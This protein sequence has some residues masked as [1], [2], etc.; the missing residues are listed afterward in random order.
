MRFCF[1]G[2]Y[3]VGAG[4]PVNRVLLAGLNRAGHTV[5]VCRAEVWGPFVHRALSTHNP[6]RLLLLGLRL[7]RGWGQLWWR[8]RRLE[9][10]PDWIVV[11][12]PGFFD[13]HLAHWLARGRPVALVSF[14]SLYD[15]IVA[16]R[17][18]LPSGSRVAGLLKQLDR[19]A[20][21]AADAVLVD[22]DEQARYY[23]D[24]F[25]LDPGRFLRSF[26]G[27]DDVEFSFVPPAPRGPD[28][29]RV[30]FFGTYV[31]L[32][33]IE[34]VID[35]AC[36]LRQ[37]R[38]IQ[39][40]LIGNGQMYPRMRERARTLE[41]EAEFI[42]HWVAPTE[43]VR[44]IQEAHVCLGVFGTTAKAARVIPYKVFD[45]AAVGRAIITCDS[46]AAREMLTDGESALLCPAGD[47]PAL[48]SAV[49]RL[50][51]DDGLRLSLAQTAHAVYRS[52]GCP[53]AV[54]RD[55]ARALQERSESG[56]VAE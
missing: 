24:I 37:E 49:R 4:Y 45:A 9:C 32:H 11:G 51:D 27:E 54:G 40:C 26:V 52:H 34:T 13:V 43:L 22:T 2:T 36:E 53:E 33:G 41:V 44:H 15:T 1:F 5:D 56:K 30:L 29:L 48:A 7:V 20:F 38:D 18:R 35:A 21:Q 55:L 17:A 46:P 39:F 25:D 19:S 23:A 28:P 50:R 47:G 12:Y 14:I 6:L 10:P 3:T 42:D 31:P 8:F 16:D